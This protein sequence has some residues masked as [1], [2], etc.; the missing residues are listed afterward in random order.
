MVAIGDW[1]EL[2][3]LY[4][5]TD[6]SCLWVGLRLVEFG[7]FV[8][9]VCGWCGLALAGVYLFSCFWVVYCLCAIG[10]WD[11]RVGGCGGFGRLVG[12]IWG[13]VM[14]RVWVC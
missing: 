3:W 12:W 4:L 8:V 9:G 13:S 2:V 7:W 11:L 14:W 5:W 6:G 10:S 1:V